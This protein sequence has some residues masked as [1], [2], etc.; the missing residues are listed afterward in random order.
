M[1]RLKESGKVVTVDQTFGLEL[2][3]AIA[4]TLTLKTHDK[5]K[6]LTVQTVWKR[7]ER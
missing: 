7:N 5:D 2:Q 6:K 4:N 1:G 3:V